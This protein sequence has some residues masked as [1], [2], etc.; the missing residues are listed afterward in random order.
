MK[1][2]RAD[3]AVA[4]IIGAILLLA[5]AVAAISVIY[6]YVLSDKG[7]SPE[8]YVTIIGKMEPN[9]GINNTVAF[10]NR[11]G[12]TLGPDTEIML[13]IAGQ[14][15]PTMKISDFPLLNG[16]WDIGEKIYPAQNLGDLTDVQ[17][18]A[19]IV[20]EKSNSMVFWGRLQEGYVVPP[21]GRGGIWHFDEPWWNGT[22]GE[23]KDSSGNG[24][25]GTARNGAQIVTDAQNVVSGHAGFFD[26]V[27]DYVEVPSSYSLN[28]ID[29]IT[30]EAYIKPIEGI[31]TLNWSQYGPAFAYSPNI[32][33]VSKLKLLPWL[34]L[35]LLMRK[36]I[37][38]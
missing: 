34:C 16:N 5:I 7:P 27:D 17:I 36:N 23:V 29:A 4:E 30:V 32:I 22:F 35:M 14:Q 6:V 24:N 26:E 2:K 9:G 38:I 1:N 33:L 10:E 28:I 37:Y 8:T 19:T 21:F 11:R 12:E 31:R 13:T 18:D 15:K 25:N 20:D 3:K